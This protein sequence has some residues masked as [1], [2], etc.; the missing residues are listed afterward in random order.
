VAAGEKDLYGL[1]EIVADRFQ[2][3]GSRVLRGRGARLFSRGGPA[4]VQMLAQGSEGIRALGDERRS[5]GN[6]D[7]TRTWRRTR[8]T[9][10][11]CTC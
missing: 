10:S 5:S 9:R 6:G 2:T 4:L 8:R 1:L 11:P 3:L 7:R